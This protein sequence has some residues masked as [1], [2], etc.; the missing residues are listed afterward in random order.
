MKCF[1]FVF[2]CLFFISASAQDSTLFHHT[3]DSS[4]IIRNII[5]TGNTKTKDNIILREV[6][7]GIGDTIAINDLQKK[8]T[9]AK[10]QVI[11]TSLFIDVAI[12]T[13]SIDNHHINVTINVKE[14]WYLLPI[15]YFRLVA[16][17]FNAGNRV[18]A[19]YTYFWIALTSR[20]F[21]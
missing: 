18:Q 7:F 4:F 17:N 8:L 3:S 9:L 14:R 20:R 2:C 21:S 5:I 11:N 15:P 13:F 12:D 19:S 16:R 6:P 1:A 10:Q